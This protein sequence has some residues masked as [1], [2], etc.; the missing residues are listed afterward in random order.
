MVLGTYLFSMMVNDIKTVSPSTSILVKFADDLTLSVLVNVNTDISS[1]QVENITKWADINLMNLNVKKALEI[2]V[3]GR[4][5]ESLPFQ[6]GEI[7]RATF[8]KLLS[9]ILEE[10]RTR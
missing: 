8:L 5:N 3:R 6:T 9:I 10:D 2:I 7:R 1:I 4:R